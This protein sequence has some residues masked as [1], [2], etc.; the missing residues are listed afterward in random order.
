MFSKLIRIISA[1]FAIGIF[2]QVWAAPI[3]HYVGT[4]CNLGNAQLT[5]IKEVS[6]AANPAD[7]VV[8][9][10][11]LLVNGPY[12][13]TGCLVFD[14]NDD[15]SDPVINIGQNGDGFLNTTY[16][17]DDSLFFIEP[18]ELQNLDDIPFEV[19]DDPG[20]IQLADVDQ[21]LNV[22][23]DQ[24]GPVTPGGL[25]LDIDALL[26]MSFT[27][28]GGDVGECTAVEWVIQTDPYI[29]E[30]VQQL[31]G[32]ATFDHLAFSVKVAG[33]FIIYDFDFVDIF[34]TEPGLNFLT[35][36]QLSGTLNTGDFLNRQGNPQAISHMSVWARD[37]ADSSVVVSEPSSIGILILALMGTLMSRLARRKQ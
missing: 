32:E 7:G 35:P 21:N 29:I 31:L 19:A 6:A 11:E 16:G 30:Q 10:D 37:P 3:T 18:D 17:P 5:S 9:S 25:F 20:W 12:D 14:G 8:L 1:V 36:Y 2:G 33:S 34:E 26:D 27:C 28:V 23:Y 15:P 4:S 24:S 22:T 13:A